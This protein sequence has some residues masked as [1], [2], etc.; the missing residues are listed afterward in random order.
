M[1]TAASILGP[2][3]RIAERLRGYEHRQQQ[4]D[5]ADAVEQAINGKRHLLVEAGTGV[6]KT[7]AYL[8]PAILWATANEDRPAGDEEEDEPPRRRVV[9]STHTISL[10]EQLLAKDLPLLNSVIPR[11][12]SSVLV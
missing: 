4:L 11:E 1:L 10:Q 7:F 6:G 3:G 8:T 9:V 12:F 5:M 2:N